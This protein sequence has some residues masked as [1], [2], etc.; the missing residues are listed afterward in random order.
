MLTSLHIPKGILAEAVHSI[1]FMSTL[2][3]PWPPAAPQLNHFPAMIFC[4]LTLFTRGRV[5]LLDSADETPP[6]PLADWL[7]TGP[8][9]QPVTSINLAPL[10]CVAP[11][12]YPDAFALLTGISPKALQDRDESASDWLDDDWVEWPAALNARAGQPIKQVRWMEDWLL[13]RWQQARTQWHPELGEQR[14]RRALPNLAAA[15]QKIGLGQRQL[16]RHYQGK[17][18]LT[19]A[20]T[21]RV[22][23]VHDAMMQVSAALRTGESFRLAD[24]AAELGY[25]DQAHFARDM[26]ELVGVPMSELVTGLTEQNKYWAYRLYGDAFSGL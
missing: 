16:Q 14:R 8:R 19:P 10:Q 20:Q 21:R 13:P 9:L 5:A 4:I 11:L 22:Q 26:R 25:A 17:V 23:R 3:E 15:A 6:R 1:V 24:L 18:G 7:I 12:F 2:D